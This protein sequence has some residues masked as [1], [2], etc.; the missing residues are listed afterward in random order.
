MSQSRQGGEIPGAK[1]ITKTRHDVGLSDV[2][3]AFGVILNPHY[4]RVCMNYVTPLAPQFGNLLPQFIAIQPYRTVSGVVSSRSYFCCP[5]AM[6]VVQCRPHRFCRS[7]Q[8]SSLPQSP[9][10]RTLDPSSS[11]PSQEKGGIRSAQTLTAL[12][13]CFNESSAV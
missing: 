9:S 3:T 8:S 4:R 11:P 6:L 1:D 12:W 13:M 10:W 5:L 7:S 2:L